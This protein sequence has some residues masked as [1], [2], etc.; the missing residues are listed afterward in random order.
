M[1]DRRQ[2]LT[3]FVLAS[4]FILTLTS[5]PYAI[6][7]LSEPPGL[8]FAGALIAPD[9]TLSYLAK[10]QQGRLGSWVFHL[11][12]TGQNHAGVP[13]VYG[14]YILLGHVARWSSLPNL[15]VFHLA[16]LFNGFFLLTIAYLLIVQASDDLQERRT[17]FM[18]VG[19]SSG[20]G[21]L[22][23]PLGFYLSTDLTSP[24]SNTFLTLF[25]NAHFSLAQA[26]L[27]SAL[28]LLAVS[29]TRAWRRAGLF[30]LATMFLTLL[31]PFEIAPVAGVA[32][33]YLAARWLK[34]KR[35]PLAL[36]AQIG[37]ALVAAVPLFALMWY[38]LNTDPLL[39]A[40]SLGQQLITP[41]VWH[42]ISGYGLVLAAAVPGGVIAFKR[43]RPI[44][45]VLLI[46]IGVTL[47]L[48]YAPVSVQR[49]FAAG[50]HIPLAILAAPGLG[51]WAKRWPLPRRWLIIRG[52]TVLTMM[53]TGVIAILYSAGPLL[54]N[55][56]LY[57]TKNEEAALVWLRDNAEPDT[58]ILSSTE[59]GRFVPVYSAGR[60]V[61]GHGMETINAEA[62]E[63]EVIEFYADSTSPARRLA[64]L[65]AHDVAYVIFGS[66]ETAL[67]GDS[68][69]CLDNLTLLTRVG[70]VEVYAAIR[71]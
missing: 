54:H 48:L 71:R 16:R 8:K 58:A 70:D 26:L 46:W 3:W 38:V 57:L 56:K 41:P 23:L 32:L 28:L 43:R 35:F 7:H 21:W 2:E 17:A 39:R 29:T 40:W 13:L 12:Y 65:A 30:A 62:T 27:A 45:L 44:D 59:L 52:L 14:Y 37:L 51:H 15:V 42:Y 4:V 50:L 11:P 66:R 24:E 53:T 6:G 33:F 60:A 63:A 10:M 5:I 1:N 68:R 20:F 64:I 31:Q 36:A 9:D 22:V 18:L 55:S 49:R 69:N 67:S 25:D 61:S 34:D 47:A 19:L